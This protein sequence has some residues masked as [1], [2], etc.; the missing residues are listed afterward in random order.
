MDSPMLTHYM[1]VCASVGHGC[2]HVTQPLYSSRVL[3]YLGMHG[4]MHRARGASLCLLRVHAQTRLEAV[5]SKKWTWDPNT[6]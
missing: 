2:M 3:V 6:F 5:S 1:D 4:T